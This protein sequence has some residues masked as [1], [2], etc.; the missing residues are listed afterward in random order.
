MN[1]QPNS[2][3]CFVCGRN[4]PHG[5]YMSFYDDGKDMVESHY[6]VSKSFEGYPGIVHGGVQA[7]ILDE[8]IGRV[9]LIEDFHAFMMSVRLDVKYRHPVPVGE[10]LHVVAKREHLRGRYAQAVGMI[11]LA[12]GKLATEASMKLIRLPEEFREDGDPSQVLGWRVDPSEL[13]P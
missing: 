10:L 4:N 8:I 3:N 11:Y 9:S 7:A 1:K 6:R 5:L 12:D 13:V 2:D